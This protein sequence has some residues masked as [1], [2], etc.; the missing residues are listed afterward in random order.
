MNSTEQSRV[1][2]GSGLPLASIV[3]VTW[4][5]KRYVEECLQSLRENA[6][7]TT[8]VLLVDNAS[9]DG[10][11]EMVR[12]KFPEVHLV[13]NHDNLGFARGN[14]AA[15]PCCRGKYLFLINSDVNVPSHCLA[16]LIDY[17]EQ[18]PDIGLMG[19]Q[20][21][22]PSKQVR[23]SSMRCPTLWNLFWRAFGVDSIPHCGGW[24]RSLLM[25]DFGHDYTRDVEVLNGWFWVVRRE[26]FEQVGMLDE[27]FF[28]YGE[29]WDWSKRFR[30]HGW[31][32]VFYAG[33]SA[34]HYG[35]ASS[36]VAPI[37]SYLETQRANLQYWQKH[38]NRVSLFA[39]SVVLF[40]HDLL[41][42]VGHSAAFMSKAADRSVAAAKVSR[43]VALLRSM[44]RGELQ[45]TCPA[46]Y[47]AFEHSRE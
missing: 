24:T 46:R 2:S 6:D 15:L 3:I 25:S 44:V 33:A 30:D 20:M 39:Y 9:T 4:N 42:I 14:N 27:R 36:A 34:I 41:R 31:R 1:E 35:G 45:S 43:S 23:R 22:G 8:E 16:R 10:T 37:R 12:N 29:D 21:L 28:M 47:G 11:P 17:M 13:E 19:P 18:H 32:L 40:L 26:A 7:V 38:H 5:G